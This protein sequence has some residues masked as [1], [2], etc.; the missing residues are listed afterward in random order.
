VAA[1]YCD[2]RDVAGYSVVIESFTPDAQRLPVC[3]PYSIACIIAQNGGN[4]ILGP[5]PQDVDIL[6]SCDL[7]ALAIAAAA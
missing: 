4:G 2:I 7:A 3:V 6:V 1:L 5:I